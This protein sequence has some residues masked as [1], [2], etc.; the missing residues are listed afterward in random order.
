M[1]NVIKKYKILWKNIIWGLLLCGM[2]EKVFFKIFKAQ[3]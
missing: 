3:M 1:I 2:L